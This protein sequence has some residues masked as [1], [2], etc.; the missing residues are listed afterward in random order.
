[1]VTKS[2][3][4]PVKAFAAAPSG[5]APISPASVRAST[6]TT[7]STAVADCAW[8]RSKA[9]APWPPVASVSPPPACRFRPTAIAAKTHGAWWRSCCSQIVRRTSKPRSLR[10]S[11]FKCSATRWGCGRH[12]SRP[13]PMCHR[14]TSA[15]PPSTSTCAAASCAPT[16]CGL[17]A[18]SST[19]Q[20]SA[21]RG[22]ANT[23]ASCSIK[24]THWD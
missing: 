8:S 5:W 14:A 16:A 18:K 15:I 7:A 6:R 19:T 4:C 20:S 24:M 2:K 23:H 21:S 9:S 10:P 22:A 17:A 12:A 11:G 3:H 13:T 1:M